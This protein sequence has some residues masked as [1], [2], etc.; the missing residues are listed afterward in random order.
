MLSSDF[1]NLLNGQSD[2]SQLKGASTLPWFF[3]HTILTARHFK[4][5]RKSV[6]NPVLGCS[7]KQVVGGPG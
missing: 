4:L 6:R 2:E 7:A 5:L 1:M 3:Q